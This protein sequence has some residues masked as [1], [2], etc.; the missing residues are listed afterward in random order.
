MFFWSIRDHDEIIIE[1]WQRKAWVTRGRAVAICGADDRQ[2]KFK[3]NKGRI[4][5]AGAYLKQRSP[6]RPFVLVDRLSRETSRVFFEDLTDSIGALA[7]AS[8]LQGRRTSPSFVLS[9]LATEYTLPRR[10]SFSL[11]I[12]WKAWQRSSPI[13]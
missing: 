11:R 12:A 4:F 2:N 1:V 9:H 5:V 13:L 3:T 7:F 8:D 6:H 10:I